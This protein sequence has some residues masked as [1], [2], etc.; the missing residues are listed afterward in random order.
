M[1]VL[2]YEGVFR[3]IFGQCG[4]VY[5]RARVFLEVTLRLPMP[6]ATQPSREGRAE[7]GT[8]KRTPKLPP[9]KNQKRL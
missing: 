9:K 2:V 5:R 3:H 4:I 1:H 7:A 6:C 8:I